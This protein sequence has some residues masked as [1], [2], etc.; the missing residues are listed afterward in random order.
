MFLASLQLLREV[1]GGLIRDLAKTFSENLFFSSLLNDKKKM[2]LLKQTVI[3]HFE[4]FRSA[5]TLMMENRNMFAFFLVFK[6]N[7]MLEI[8][9]SIDLRKFCPFFALVFV[10]ISSNLLC[11]FF[12]VPK[13][14]NYASRAEQIGQ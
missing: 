4:I 3:T 6:S 1:S 14:E 5:E 9:N 13:D 11:I 8:L 2:K 7:K 10:I 12:L